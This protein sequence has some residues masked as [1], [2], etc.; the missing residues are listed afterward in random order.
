MSEPTSGRWKVSLLTK[1][2][3]G[4]ALGIF[5]GLLFGDGT[6]A[7]GG[8]EFGLADIR[9]V[10]DLFLRLIRIRRSC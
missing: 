6:V 8:R 5:A 10:G 3:L 2:F 7:V 4:M 1:I 9:F